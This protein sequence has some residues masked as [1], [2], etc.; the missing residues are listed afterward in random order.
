MQA[1]IYELIK[2]GLIRNSDSANTHTHT[3]PSLIGQHFAALV[4]VCMSVIPRLIYA[5]SK[6]SRFPARLIAA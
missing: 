3:H 1:L 5:D 6:K 4:C 2:K